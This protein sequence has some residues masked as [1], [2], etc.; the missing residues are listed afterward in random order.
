[1][2][3][4]VNPQNRLIV[5]GNPF[6]CDCGMGWLMNNRSQYLE[7]VIDAVCDDYAE[8]WRLDDVYFRKCRH[9]THYMPRLLF[10]N[11]VIRVGDIGLTVLI[12]LFVAI[13]NL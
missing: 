9:D 12:G 2:F 13:N 8:L 6:E 11:S 3:L 7:Q 1:M 4:N 10:R 5:R